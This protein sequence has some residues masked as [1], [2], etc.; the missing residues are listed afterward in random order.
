VV[1]ADSTEALLEAMRTM[2]DDQPRTRAM[3]R[4]A[5]RYTEERS[6]EA[7]FLQTWKMSHD[8]MPATTPIDEMVLAM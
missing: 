7:A 4:A 6:F 5:R 2:V 3:G 1:P 8:V